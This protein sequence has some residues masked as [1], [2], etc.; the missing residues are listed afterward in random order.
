MALRLTSDSLSSVDYTYKPFQTSSAVRIG[1]R[2]GS[3]MQFPS[4]E[5][6]GYF[7]WSYPV[8]SIERKSWKAARAR[9][10]T[11][12]SAYKESGKLYPPNILSNT[13]N[14][15]K[16][17]VDKFAMA[18]DNAAIDAVI[19][20]LKNPF[21]LFG[22]WLIRVDRNEVDGV[23]KRFACDIESGKLPYRAK[24]STARKNLSLKDTP[25]GKHLICVYTPNYLW[26]EDVR[27]AR[28]LLRKSGFHSRL[29]YR[30]DIITILELGS[31]AGTDFDRVIFRYLRNY[32]VK[33][34]EISYRYYG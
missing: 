16:T 21:V 13:P 14:P 32:G 4:K 20:N 10:S 22:K 26:R 2:E 33:R 7:I 3:Q 17:Q 28:I 31:V 6:R 24:I 23:W 5:K 11:N 18:I 15:P 8:L 29:Y 19:A 1:T 25:K 30:P 12:L 34:P 27:A 9:I